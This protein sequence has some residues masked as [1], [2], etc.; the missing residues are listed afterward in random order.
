MWKKIIQDR[1]IEAEEKSELGHLEG[2][3]IVSAGKNAYVLTLADRKSMYLWGIPIRSKGSDIVCRAVVESL[4]Q[5]PSGFIKTITEFNSYRLIEKALGCTVYFADPYSSWQRAIN[6]HQNGRI[7]QYLPKNISFA[8][9][10]DDEYQDILTSINN[11][12]R[13]S[14]NWYSSTSL[15]EDSL[16]AF[17]T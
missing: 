12:P 5:L 17:K 7:R 15:L 4:E 1:P 8:G 3:L 16:V 14:R 10:T 2:D 11:R 13:K 9:L 6:E